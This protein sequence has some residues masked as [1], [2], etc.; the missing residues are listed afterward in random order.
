MSWNR[1]GQKIKGRY[2]GQTPY[3]GTVI[4]SRVA[5]GARIK[6]TV[7]LDESITVYGIPRDTIIV[8][9]GITSDLKTVLSWHPIEV[10]E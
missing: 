1:E 9:E 10:I 6:H 5:Y 3:I 7:E 8:E 4:N 2:L